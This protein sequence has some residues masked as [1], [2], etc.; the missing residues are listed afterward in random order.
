MEA[1]QTNQDVAQPELENTQG[2]ETNETTETQGEKPAAAKPDRRT[3]DFAELR[4]HSKQLER[5]VKELSEN[6][7]RATEPRL[8]DESTL[9]KPRLSDY[10]GDEA[11]FEKAM[12][13]Y[14]RSLVTIRSQKQAQEMR[15]QNDQTS[16]EM[17][18]INHEFERKSSFAEKEIP[19]LKERYERIQ[20]EG[21]GDRIDGKV[22]TAVK[23]SPIAPYIYAY[24]EEN[25]NETRELEALSPRE[26]LAELRAIESHIQRTRWVPSASQKSGNNNSD[27]QAQRNIPQPPKDRLKGGQGVTHSS[28]LATASTTEEYF[29]RMRAERA[30]QRKR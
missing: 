26:Q 12:E 16:G 14:S 10:K 15:V 2:V 6:L 11:G 22:V 24:L 23:T 30:A 29:H 19:D 1:E 17:R 7:K 8:P 27:A 28:S 25:R 13:D 9:R 21:V 4:A 18:A 20:K 3:S 5:T